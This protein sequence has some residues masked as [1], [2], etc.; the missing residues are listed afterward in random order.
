MSINFKQFGGV[1]PTLDNK[2]K[3]TGIPPG[4]AMPSSI[5]VDEDA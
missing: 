1:A 3:L 2:R 5:L 4:G